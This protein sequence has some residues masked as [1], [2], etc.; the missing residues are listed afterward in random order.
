MDRL[1]SDSPLLGGTIKPHD[2]RCCSNSHG[3]NI[4]ARWGGGGKHD[5]R[6]CGDVLLF[7]LWA[8][9]FLAPCNL[10]CFGGTVPANV[11]E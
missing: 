11:Q 7:P 1:S 8:S 3:V 10:Q 6:V 2:S 5:D 9:K 4:D